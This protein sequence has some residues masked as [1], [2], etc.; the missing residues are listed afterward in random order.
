MAL[1]GVSAKEFLS[2]LWG[3]APGIA[4]LMVIRDGKASS[5]PFTYP[6]SLGSLIGAALQHNR[7]ANVY[8]GVCLRAEKWPRP[9]GELDH[10]GKP[11]T[12]Y[13][14]TE[15]NT[16]SSMAVW[17]EVDFAG[18]LHKGKTVIEEDLRRCLKE[19]PL[20]PSAIVRTGGGIHIY[21]LL[22]E[23]ATG[24]DLWRVKASNKAVANHLGADAQCSDLARILRVPGTKN[25]KYLPP[26]VCQVTWWKPESRYTLD[27]FDFLAPEITRPS[28]APPKTYLIPPKSFASNARP[29]P[30]ITLPLDVTLKIGELFSLMWLQGH[31]HELS[32]TVSGF[33]AHAGISFHSACAVVA[34]ASDLAGSP[35]TDKRLRSVKDT[36]DKFAQGREVAGG[37][38]I[39]RMISE[40][41][42]LAQRQA[43][44]ECFLQVKRLL[45]RTSLSSTRARYGS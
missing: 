21:W 34:R 42:P 28:D 15:R 35:H 2:A 11:K 17:C 20:K 23:P 25:Y 13:R 19:F 44:K 8:M 32:L 31:R 36:Y 9:S 5:Y 4:E 39:D 30:T 12:E 10:E 27:D 43:A 18:A 29:L 6:E 37:S 7:T 1:P 3:D 40:D 16:K 33:L 22:K 41:L 24:D 38:S 14:G 45:P 26:S